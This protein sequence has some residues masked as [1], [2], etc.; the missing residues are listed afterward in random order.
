MDL[1]CFPS[2]IFTTN[3]HPALILKDIN[4]YKKSHGFYFK[5]YYR[6]ERDETYYFFHANILTNFPLNSMDG[7][8][9]MTFDCTILFCKCSYMGIF[10]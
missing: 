3:L 1:W 9:L 7:L 6:Y 4:I 5:L 8:V 10:L 2:P